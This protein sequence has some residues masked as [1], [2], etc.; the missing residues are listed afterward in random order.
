MPAVQYI[1]SRHVNITFHCSVGYYVQP[2]IVETIDPQ[3][4]LLHEEVFGPVLTVYVFE[5]SKWNDVVELVDSTSPYGL[6]GS[7][8]CTNRSA[9]CYLVLLGFFLLLIIARRKFD[10]MC[11]FFVINF[12]HFKRNLFIFL[13]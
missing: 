12:G 9:I 3:C 5:D 8:F 13:A 2:T 7:I 4:K 1:I 6:T 11:F 10:C